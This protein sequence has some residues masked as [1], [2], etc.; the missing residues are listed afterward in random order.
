MYVTV[1]LVGSLHNFQN[2][3]FLIPPVFHPPMAIPKTLVFHDSKQDATDAT[4]YLN[5]W[6]P[7]N[8]RN[9]GIVKHYH[10]DMLAEYIQATF[11]DF[12]A[13]NGTCHVPHATAGASTVSTY[14]LHDWN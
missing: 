11:E 13:D 1:P 3:D 6:L 10:S 8:I 9:H 12:S 5:E 7:Q 2:L 4:T 14:V